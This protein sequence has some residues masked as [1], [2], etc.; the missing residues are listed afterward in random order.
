M[1]NKETTVLEDG[2]THYN[3]IFS[4]FKEIREEYGISG[5]WQEI[6]QGRM[7]WWTNC[8]KRVVK[9]DPDNKKST[10]TVYWTE[11]APVNYGSMP[12]LLA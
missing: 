10:Y 1:K 7:G 5:G 4:T 11:R 6:A 3:E 9:D 8:G 2:R 12:C